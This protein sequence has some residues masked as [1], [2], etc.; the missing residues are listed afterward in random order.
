MVST[1]CNQGWSRR[2]F[3][4]LWDADILFS[5]VD[6]QDV[7]SLRQFFAQ[8]DAWPEE[9]PAANG[10]ALV[11]CGFAGLRVCGLE[12][13]LDVLSGDDAVQWIETDLKEAVLSF[14]DFYQGGA[15]LIRWAPSGRN[16]I[17]MK[18]TSEEYFWTEVSAFYGG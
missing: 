9:L 4:L 11:V 2:G 17:S 15:G 1:R 3:A 12:G 10:D 6:R 7:V 18:T 8:V 5:L 14:Q 13:C 16:R